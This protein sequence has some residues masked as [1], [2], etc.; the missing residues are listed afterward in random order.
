MQCLETHADGEGHRSL[1]GGVQL[2]RRHRIFILA[3][4]ELAGPSSSSSAAAED[5]WPANR[6]GRGRTTTYA[7]GVAKRMIF[8]E[9]VSGFM[10]T[11]DSEEG[12]TGERPMPKRIPRSPS[13]HQSANEADSTGFCSIWDPT[14]SAINAALQECCVP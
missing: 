10:T 4:E 12:A 11:G 8:S 14:I 7:S 2:W 9:L 3:T 13:S 1:C 6:S 5:A